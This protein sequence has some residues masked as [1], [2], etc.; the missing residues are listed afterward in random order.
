M[1]IQQNEDSRLEVGLAYIDA[2]VIQM[3][4]QQVSRDIEY[5]RQEYYFSPEELAV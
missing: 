2:G 3:A 1:I 5:T 4:V